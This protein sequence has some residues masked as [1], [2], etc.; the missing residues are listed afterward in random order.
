MKTKL[1]LLI[2][3]IL[4][5]SCVAVKSYQQVNLNDPDMKLSPNKSNKFVMTFQ[6]YREGTAGANG[7]KSGGGCGCN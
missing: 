3:G 1:L 7:G 5:T 2:A 4:L 6:V